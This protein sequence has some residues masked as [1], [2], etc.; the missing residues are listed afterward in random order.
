M[1]GMRR[2]FALQQK[3]R[4]GRAAA[5]LINASIMVETSE[6]P[7]YYISTVVES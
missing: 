2:Y 6:I 5:A 1:V 7:S 3:N 4:Q